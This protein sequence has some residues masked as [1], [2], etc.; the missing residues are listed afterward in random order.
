MEDRRIQTEHNRIREDK[1]LKFRE[2]YE[3]IEKEI[4]DFKELINNANLWHYS[5]I[6][7]GYMK[8]VKRS[9]SSAAEFMFELI[10]DELL[11]LITGSDRKE[12]DS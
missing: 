3:I 7:R 9:K 12:G 4:S 10:F 8:E 6:I 1:H 11:S 2:E 5:M